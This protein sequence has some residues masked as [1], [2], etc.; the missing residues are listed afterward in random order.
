MLNFYF[1]IYIFKIDLFHYIYV[2]IYISASPTFESEPVDTRVYLGQIAAFECRVAPT[3][4]LSS[5]T[6]AS[7]FSSQVNTRWIK[8]D[9]YLVLD[10]RM[11][12]LPSGML[13]ISDVAL[14]DRG[15]YKC[16]VSNLKDPQSSQTSRSATLVV[17]LNMGMA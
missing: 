15:E 16:R 7:T 2:Y 17:N 12:I 4:F 10:H 13:E 14:S 5:R 3:S 1:Y 11:K 8:D 9:Q 6:T